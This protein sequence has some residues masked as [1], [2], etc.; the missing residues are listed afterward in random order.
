MVQ[1]FGCPSRQLRFVVSSSAV[2]RK[3][4]AGI[5]A[6]MAFSTIAT[7]GDRTGLS[8][9]L[10]GWDYNLEIYVSSGVCSLSSVKHLRTTFRTPKTLVPDK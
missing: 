2:I 7:R 6:K 4:M 5:S 1:Y 10:S 9:G 8:I 3:K